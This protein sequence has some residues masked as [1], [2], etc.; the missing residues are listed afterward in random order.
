[1][2]LLVFFNV[3]KNYKRPTISGPER[4][5]YPYLIDQNVKEGFKD[6]EGKHI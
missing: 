4:A 5:I 6:L 3:M 1:M 2:V